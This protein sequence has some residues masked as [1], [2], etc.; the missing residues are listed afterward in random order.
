M[1][2]Q[3]SEERGD[4]RR[5]GGGHLRERAVTRLSQR[6]LAR[7]IGLGRGLLRRRTGLI[8]RLLRR[9]A[10]GPVVLLSLGAHEH[11]V[12]HRRLRIELIA[13]DLR[14]L[15]EQEP[16]QERVALVAGIGGDVVG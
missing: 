4:A 10:V 7:I 9:T 3:A 6:L 1:E 12:R 14:R 11:V 13:P 8:G 2:T 15:I 5:K 16:T